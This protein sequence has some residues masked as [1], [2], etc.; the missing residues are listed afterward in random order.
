M[1]NFNPVLLELAR[2]TLE[3]D[4]VQ[5]DVTTTSLEEFLKSRGDALPEKVGFEIRAKESGIFSGAVWAQAIAVQMGLVIDTHLSEGEDFVPGDVVCSGRGSPQSILAAERSLLNGMQYAC[6]VAVR[7]NEYVEAVQSVWTRAGYA[8]SAPTVHHTRKTPPGLRELA[9]R[10]VEAGGGERHRK[11]L[12]D[13]ILFKE[14]H[15]Y[16]LLKNAHELQDYVAYLVTWG[17]ED[18]IVE[19]EN[20]EEALACAQ[21]GAPHLLL[22]N[23][24]PEQV[25]EF[26]DSSQF[27]GEVEVSG[28]LSLERIGDYCYPGVTRFSVGSLTR[29]V[30][31]VDLSLDWI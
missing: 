29:D 22:D 13:R 31:T 10:A 7:T 5:R 2:Q 16:F 25:K 18:F 15:K 3:E 6:G 14:N 20:F 28:G 21:A 12:S 24:T 27:S 4:T 19:V 17:F 30:R 9:L 23:F 11:D 26:V 8:G 1:E